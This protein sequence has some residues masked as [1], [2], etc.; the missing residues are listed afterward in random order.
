MVINARSTR[1]ING[2]D[3]RRECYIKNMVK[4]VQRQWNVRR[5]ESI[6]N[7]SWFYSAVRNTAAQWNK[8]HSSGRRYWCGIQTPTFKWIKARSK[9]RRVPG[10]NLV[11]LSNASTVKS[12]VCLAGR[13]FTLFHVFNGTDAFFPWGKVRSS[14]E[15]V[16]L[17]VWLI[18]KNISFFPSCSFFLVVHHKPNVDHNFSCILR[19]NAYILFVKLNVWK[20]GWR[21]RPWDTKRSYLEYSIDHA[22]HVSNLRG[23]PSMQCWTRPQPTN[24]TIL[25]SIQGVGWRG[26]L[27][28]G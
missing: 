25:Q 17:R 16:S 2:T 9:D 24:F 20:N 4:A 18:G 1:C 19:L 5:R 8:I 23:V 10:E 7:R 28:Q 21:S 3:G 14:I 12:L 11:L 22:S 15:R 26:R 27:V 6:L 13:I